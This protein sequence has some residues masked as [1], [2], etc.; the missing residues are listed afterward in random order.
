M[1][2]G[3][4]A[5]ML[6]MIIVSDGT[7]FRFFAHWHLLVLTFDFGLYRCVLPATQAMNRCGVLKVPIAA[8]VVRC[9]FGFDRCRVCSKMMLDRSQPAFCLKQAHVRSNIMPLDWSS[10]RHVVLFISSASP[11]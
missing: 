5:F 1:G 4:L 9:L 2:K 3:I 10:S 11:F 8:T 6:T 7:S